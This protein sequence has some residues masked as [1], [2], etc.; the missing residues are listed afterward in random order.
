[1]IINRRYETQKSSGAVG[2][3]LRG[4]VKDLS[5]P[6]YIHYGGVGPKNSQLWADRIARR[7]NVLDAA[8]FR[9]CGTNTALRDDNAHICLYVRVN[10]TYRAGYFS[11]YQE[12]GQVIASNTSTDCMGR[13]QTMSMQD[14]RG[15]QM[16]GKTTNG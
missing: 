1:M 13:Q 6:L 12:K 11:I 4:R 15:R 3:Y 7:R 8:N 9:N 5:P 16:Q 10:S 2:C 14:C